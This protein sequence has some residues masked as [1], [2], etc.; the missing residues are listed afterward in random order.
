[1]LQVQ[2]HEAGHLLV[3]RQLGFTVRDAWASARD[4]SGEVEAEILYSPDTASETELQ[5]R[6]FAAGGIAAEIAYY[7]NT[8][9]RERDAWRVGADLE[10]GEWQT[11]GELIAHA[12]IVAPRMSRHTIEQAAQDVRLI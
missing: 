2:V 6:D 10:L 1:M 11:V 7:G 5:V 9:L 8:T 12:R 3:A 4:G